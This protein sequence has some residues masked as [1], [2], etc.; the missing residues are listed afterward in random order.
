MEPRR[1]LLVDDHFLFRQGMASIL[2]SHPAIEV[3]GEADNGVEAMAMAR[4]LAPDLVLM[5]LR[6]PIQDGLETL[7]L[8]KH[9]MP[10]VQVVM[11]TISDEDDDLF[12]AL[13]FGADGYLL[14]NM[15]PAQFFE[16]L[17]DLQKDGTA[18]SGHV[19]ARILQELRLSGSTP[20]EAQKPEH[21]LTC[22]EHEVLEQL[23]EGV[24]NKEIAEALSIRENT[25][26]IHVRHILEKLQ[27]QNRLQAAV[28]AVREGVLDESRTG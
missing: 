22:R 15:S 26:K 20:E 12:A 5:D 8:M 28:Y 10:H 2:S 18:I 7:R 23:V 14:K 11:L 21:K 27:V 9:E 16:R 25:V 3:V 4:T 1:V 19:A 13:R 17:E 6:M 24:S